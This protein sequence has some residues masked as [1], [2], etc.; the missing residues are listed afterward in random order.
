MAKVEKFR[1]NISNSTTVDDVL[2]FYSE[3]I[4]VMIHWVS[5]LIKKARGGTLWPVLVGYH[6]L[7]VAKE[8]AGIER[9]LGSAFFA[10]GRCHFRNVS[11]LPKVGV[12]LEM[13]LF[14]PR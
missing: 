8:N 6:M 4:S 7:M 3:G 12:I 10:Q 11:F 1:S 13:C 14:C 9:A 5:K 2:A